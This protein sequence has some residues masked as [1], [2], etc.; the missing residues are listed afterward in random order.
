MYIHTNKSSQESLVCILNINRRWI[1]LYKNQMQ[2]GK[3][4]WVTIQLEVPVYMVTQM[5]L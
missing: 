2:S 4:W 1:W 3:L 5:N